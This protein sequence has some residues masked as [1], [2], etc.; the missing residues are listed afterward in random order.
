MLADAVLEAALVERVRGELREAGVHPVLDLARERS[1]VVFS[2]SII[3][4]EFG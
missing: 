3:S 2:A 4:Y 1:Q